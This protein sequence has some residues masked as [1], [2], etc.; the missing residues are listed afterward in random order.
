[1]KYHRYIS[2]RVLLGYSLILIL[3]FYLYAIFDLFQNGCNNKIWKSC[4]Q[5]HFSPIFHKESKA[6]KIIV[7]ISYL[8]G[9]YVNTHIM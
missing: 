2:F 9:F 5:G 3:F 8:L 7:S 4:E 1:M 6:E